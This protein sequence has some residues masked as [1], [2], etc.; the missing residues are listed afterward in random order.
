M[1]KFHLK[2]LNATWSRDIP[3]GHMVKIH[4]L[5]TISSQTV[6]L[7]PYRQPVLSCHKAPYLPSIVKQ[8]LLFPRV[9]ALL[10]TNICSYSFLYLKCLLLLTDYH[11][12]TFSPLSKSVFLPSDFQLSYL[13]FAWYYNYLY[14]SSSLLD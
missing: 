1:D 6:I 11:L 13:T 12:S 9:P 14:V 7:T 10:A 8:A 3:K 5:S 4:T 2:Y